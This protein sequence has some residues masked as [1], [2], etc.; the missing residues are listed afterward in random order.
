MAY[1]I[2]C[3]NTCSANE[4]I[5]SEKTYPPEH[6]FAYDRSLSMRARG[7][8]AYAATHPDEQITIKL[9]IE[10]SGKDDKKFGK[11]AAARVLN[12]IITAGYASFVGTDRL[13]YIKGKITQELREA[14]LERDGHRC[15]DCG[16]NKR[17]CADHVI[18]E[19]KGGATTIDNLQAMCRPCN[20]EKAAKVEGGSL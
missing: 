3:A 4:A 6:S 16:S 8:L 5:G 12:E 18:P 14:V 20:S 19:S 1:A 13:T 2:E 11:E 15:V 7:V 17:L 9:L 10:M